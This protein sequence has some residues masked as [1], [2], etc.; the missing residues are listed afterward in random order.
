MCTDEMAFTITNGMYDAK[1]LENELRLCRDAMTEYFLASDCD[2]KRYCHERY[3]IMTQI[4]ES[5]QN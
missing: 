4:I 3:E 5:M 1:S 2:D